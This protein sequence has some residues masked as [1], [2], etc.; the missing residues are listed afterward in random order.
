MPL[1]RRP[2][3]AEGGCRSP[4]PGRRSAARPSRRSARGGTSPADPGELQHRHVHRAA[5]RR[6]R[7]AAT[8]R[9]PSVHVHLGRVAHHVGVRDHVA[10]R[11]PPGSPS[12]C[13][14]RRRRARPRRGRRRGRPRAR[15]P[16]RLPRPRRLAADARRSAA[17][18]HQDEPRHQAAQRPPP[19]ASAST[20][21]ASVPSGLRWCAA[22]SAGRRGA[23]SARGAGGP[24]GGRSPAARPGAET[25]LHWT[26]AQ[27]LHARARR[28]HRDRDQLERP[29]AAGAA[30]CGRSPRGSS[31]TP[32]RGSATTPTSRWPSSRRSASSP[33][34]CSTSWATPSRRAATGWRSTAS[35]SGCSAASRASPGM[36]PTAGAE[37]RIA[38]AGPIVSLVL[39]G[40]LLGGTLHPRPARAGRRRCCAWLGVINAP[41]AAFNLIP[42]LPLD[43]GRMLRAALWQWKGDLQ[44]ATRIAAG[45]GR[46]LAIGHD[47]PRHGDRGARRRRSA[48]IWLALIGWFVLQ[49]AGAEAPDGAPRRRRRGAAGGRHDGRRPGH[50]PPGADAGRVLAGSPGDRPAT[51]PTPCSATAAAPSG[52]SPPAR[53]AEVPRERLGRAARV[54][55]CMVGRAHVPALGGRGRRWTRDGGAAPLRRCARVL[56]LDGRAPASGLLSL[57]DVAR[58]ARA[59]VAGP[60]RLGDGP[61]GA[62]PPRSL[63][64]WRIAR[65]N[66]TCAASAARQ[67]RPRAAFTTTSVSSMP[68]LKA[69]TSVRPASPASITTSSACFG[70]E[71]ARAWPGT[72]RRGSPPPAR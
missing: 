15:A 43:G 46:V 23:P 32:T 47:R 31:P 28:R 55:D 50:H 34:S 21:R 16:P 33:R 54:A 27:Q 37:F 67:V 48:A 19:P 64:A 17:D 18:P 51:T 72:G 25:G 20:P 29:G 36:F 26:H 38:V 39:A 60:T 4:P 40:G 45:T 6:A 59:A 5:R 3:Q 10:A 66:R 13:G 61:S 22:G 12:P 62:V 63:R 8:R 35:P 68:A 42:A 30:S 1:E 11:R 52:S 44:S 56:V 49:A 7:C 24:P 9:P 57:A 53:L 69:S 71:A 65:M 41:A 70:P 14:R 2:L 58:S